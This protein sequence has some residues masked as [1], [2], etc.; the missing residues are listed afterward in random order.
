MNVA[1]TRARM[2]LV[3]LGDAVTLGRH[4]FYRRLQEF[5]QKILQNWEET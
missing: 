3:I 4:A 2:K 1:M 5:I